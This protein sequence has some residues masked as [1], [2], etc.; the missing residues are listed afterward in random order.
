[1]C[2]ECYEKIELNAV[3]PVKIING[4]CVYSASAYADNIR[5]LIKG[6]KYH[7]K[8]ELAKDMAKILYEYWQQTDL[9]KC[10][11]E[12]VPVPLHHKRKRKRD[13]TMLALSLKNLPF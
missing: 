7:N 5:K 1:M 11:Y 8:K 2:P 6:L 4:I 13:S 10:D 9:S 12:I 3:E